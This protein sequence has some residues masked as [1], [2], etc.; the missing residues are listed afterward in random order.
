MFCLFAHFNSLNNK[1][2]NSYFAKRERKRC[3][4]THK[5]PLAGQRIPAG[6]TIN[7]VFFYRLKCLLESRISKL[8]ELDAATENRLIKEKSL[9]KLSTA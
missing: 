1:K 9:L 4:S 2:N 8:L 3:K 7:T 6:C 5:G